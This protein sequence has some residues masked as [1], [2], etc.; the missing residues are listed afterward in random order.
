MENDILH[1]TGWGLL[2]VGLFFG[3]ILLLESAKKDNELND[4]KASI[5][6]SSFI[7]SGSIILAFT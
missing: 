2:V 1:Y 6:S 4:I 3:V 5:I 7:I